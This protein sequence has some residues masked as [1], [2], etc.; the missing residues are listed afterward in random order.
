M[1]RVKDAVAKHSIGTILG[2]IVAVITIF[3]SIGGAIV[4]IDEHYVDVDEAV[5]VVSDLSQKT[6]KNLEVINTNIILLGNAFYDRRINEIKALIEEV[7]KIENKNS[8]EIQ[9]LQTLRGDLADLKR[10]QEKLQE[11]KVLPLKSNR[12]D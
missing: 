8:N 5:L 6:N 12:G 9:F 2:C 4:W 11:T 1:Q 3:G 10:Q 7:E